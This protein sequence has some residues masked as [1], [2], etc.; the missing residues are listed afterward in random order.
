M[1][2]N[3]EDPASR[4]HYVIPLN[5]LRPSQEGECPESLADEIRRYIGEETIVSNLTYDLRS[6]DPDFTAH[7]RLLS[8]DVAR[9]G[10]PGARDSDV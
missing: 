3:V 5:R 8:P 6:G 2:L 1:H 10:Q 9:P 4:S 7:P